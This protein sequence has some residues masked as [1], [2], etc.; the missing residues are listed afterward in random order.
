MAAPHDGHPLLESGIF[1]I[2]YRVYTITKVDGKPVDVYETPLGV[3]K[4]AFDTVN[5]LQINGHRIYLDGYARAPRWN[6]PLRHARRLVERNTT[7][8]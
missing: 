5:G 7:S 4:M 1:R 2:F 8:S 3:R 6:G